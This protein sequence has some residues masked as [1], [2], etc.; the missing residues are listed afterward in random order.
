MDAL[1]N[2]RVRVRESYSRCALKQTLEKAGLDVVAE[3]AIL[4]SPGG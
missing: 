2:L 3:T 4:S 1:A